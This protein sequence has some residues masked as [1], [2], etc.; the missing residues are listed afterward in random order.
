MAEIWSLCMTTSGVG[1]C[2]LT[3]DAAHRTYHETLP[4]T[5]T[6]QTCAYSPDALFKALANCLDFLGSSGEL[7]LVLCLCSD[8]S[9]CL[10]DRRGEP[11]TP[12]MT[13]LPLTIPRRDVPQIFA[14]DAALFSAYRSSLLRR[15]QLSM[16]L[17]GQE[18][19]LGLS[20]A[21]ALVIRALTGAHADIEPPLGAPAG[22]PW[23]GN[24]NAREMLFKAMGVKQDLSCLRARAGRPL[25]NVTALEPIPHCALPIDPWRSK[26][27]GIPV[28]HMGARSAC[29][30]YACAA[31]PLSWACSLGWIASAQWT[32]S[33]T[34]CSAYEIIVKDHHDDDQNPTQL[35]EQPKDKPQALT[36][37]EWTRL[38]S[39]NIDLHIVP[40]ARRNDSGYLLKTTSY[41]TNILDSALT[42]IKASFDAAQSDSPW[43]AE[44]MLAL[45]PVGSQ[46][47]HILPAAN[48]LKFAG[49]TSAHADAHLIRATFESQAYAIRSWREQTGIDGLGPIRA[50]FS[51]PWDISCAQVLCDIIAAPIFVVDEDEAA[52]ASLG[53]AVALGRDLDISSPNASPHISAWQLE[54]STQT[55]TIYDTHARI[56]SLIQS[57]LD[58]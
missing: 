22:Y 56:H 47:L 43:F 29:A 17:L 10:T 36:R 25:S 6:H 44:D 20:S 51:Q 55:A 37:D 35:D 39:E 58:F 53:A 19:P 45:V 27:A 50:I 2:A 48:D 8:R 28:F 16:P 3:L 18:S 34:A 21:A 40:G 42:R 24:D 12:I 13:E 31:D 38:I 49:L 32:A 14:D 1:A 41:R 23:P 15:L 52:L 5:R 30:A 57:K 54:P 4:Q 46:G 26:L 7:P 11:V 9:A 33:S